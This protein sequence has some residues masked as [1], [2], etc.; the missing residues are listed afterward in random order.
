MGEHARYFGSKAGGGEGAVHVVETH[1]D[2]FVVGVQGEARCV[3]YAVHRPE[4][5]RDRAGGWDVDFEAGGGGARVGMQQG[6][7]EVCDDLGDGA[8]QEVSAV[9]VSEEG[10]R[11][12]VLSEL[13]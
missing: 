6:R 10:G 12:C 11:C 3:G 1:V 7:V 9:D 5:Q 4:H 8:G 2:L 13:G